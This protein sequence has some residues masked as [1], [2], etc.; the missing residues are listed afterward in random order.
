MKHFF[1]T[2]LLFLSIL[3]SAAQELTVKSMTLVNNDL[4]GSVIRRKDT[5]GNNCALIKVSLTIGD[6]QFGGNIVGEVLREGSDYLVFLSSGSKFLQVKH[7]NFKTLMIT[8]EKYGIKSV[9]G[10]HTYLINMETGNTKVELDKK[11]N[12]VNT[13]P[14]PKKMRFEIPT[15]FIIN[16][17]AFKMI[18]VR[19]G[20]FTMG[21]DPKHIGKDKDDKHPHYVTISDYII[22]ET[23]VTQELWKSVMGYNNSTMINDNYPVDNVSWLECDE[24]VQKLKEITNLD[25]RLPTEAEW[26][27]AARGG[28]HDIG[29]LYSGG[30]NVDDIGWV[31]SNSNDN[32]HEVKSKKPNGLN[33]YDMTGNVAEWI[34]DT[35]KAYTDEPLT[36]PH[37]TEG[38]Y[39]MVRGG[40]YAWTAK[41]LWD[42]SSFST[43]INYKQKGLG[44]RL[45]LGK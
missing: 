8:F 10:N 14:D 7:S 27:F 2:T 41:Y 6:V 9:T 38:N 28:T 19:G 1:F 23:E 17:V 31:K 40:T 34:D 30:N 15:E 24:F 42:R 36:N 16:G 39:H 45:A 44:L 37:F 22:G 29:Y 26:E 43:D 11:K 13:I 18:R 5:E 3:S 32:L 35:Y 25:F 21:A 12:N 33:I 20:S 4:T